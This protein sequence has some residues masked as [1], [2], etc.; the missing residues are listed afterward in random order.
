MKFLSMEYEKRE[1]ENK[2][3]IGTISYLIKHNIYIY[4]T[5]T[6]I[7]SLSCVYFIIFFQNE[8]PRGFGFDEIK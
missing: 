7:L 2:K 6:F 5:F 4:I 1:K 3:E 8:I